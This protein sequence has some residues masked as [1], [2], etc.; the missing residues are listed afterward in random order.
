MLSF[1]ASLLSGPWKSSVH[2]FS[3]VFGRFGFGN[4]CSFLTPFRLWVSFSSNRAS[5][6]F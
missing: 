1:R 5:N 2:S 6:L 4:A 3:D